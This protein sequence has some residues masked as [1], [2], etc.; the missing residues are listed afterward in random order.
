M[1]I[2]KKVENIFP[3]NMAEIPAL[4]RQERF[5]QSHYLIDGELRRWSGPFQ[6][7][8]SPVCFAGPEGPQRVAIGTFPL[9]GERESLAALAAAVAALE[10]RQQ[11]APGPGAVL[12][13]PA[14]G[15]AEGPRWHHHNRRLQWQGSKR[16]CAST[17]RWCR[18]SR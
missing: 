5:E 1:T 16:H 11:P 8:L 2:M 18:F 4:H 7:V 9:L 3:Q 12:L 14:S 13:Q 15:L 10:E 6:E 17:I